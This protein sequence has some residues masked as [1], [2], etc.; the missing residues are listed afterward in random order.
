MRPL[1]R[2]K[3]VSAEAI[4][5]LHVLYVSV[6]QVFVGEDFAELKTESHFGGDKLSGC[7]H[8]LLHETD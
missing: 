4:N 8:L 5:E 7:H 3:S 6:L 1:K 2:A